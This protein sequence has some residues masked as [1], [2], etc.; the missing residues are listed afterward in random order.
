M[1]IGLPVVATAV[2]GTPE[3]VRDGEN[4]V[5]IEPNANG[6]LSR[7]LSRLVSSSEERQRLVTGGW[8]TTESFGRFA[9]VEK[10]ESVLRGSTH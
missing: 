4:G 7:T 8:R 5:L 1:S 2:G 10:T 3:V 9:M 6:N